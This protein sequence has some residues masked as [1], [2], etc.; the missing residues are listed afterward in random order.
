VNQKFNPKTGEM[1]QVRGFQIAATGEVV[2]ISVKLPATNQTLLLRD[3]ATGYPLWQ[4]RLLAPGRA[5]HVCDH[6][7]PHHRR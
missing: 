4:G 2:A 6:D 3:E 5:G 1:A 7:C